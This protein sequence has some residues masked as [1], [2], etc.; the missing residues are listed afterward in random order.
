[1]K[2]KTLRCPRCSQRLI[3]CEGDIAVYCDRCISTFMLTTKKPPSQYNCTFIENPHLKAD[4]YLP[5]WRYRYENKTETI[6]K[7]TT[8]NTTYIP[9]FSTSIM[10]TRNLS[11][12]LTYGKFDYRVVQGTRLF[13]ITITEDEAISLSGLFFTHQQTKLNLSS[14]NY[15][16]DILGF[17]FSY[18]DNY[19]TDQFLNFEIDISKLNKN[20]IEPW[21]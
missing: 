2:I 6:K 21:M 12:G 9:A 13:G 14:V 19:L 4:L 3:S 20:I 15:H 18:N 17:P 7:N 10:I 5:F 8:H 1:M 16:C 11:I